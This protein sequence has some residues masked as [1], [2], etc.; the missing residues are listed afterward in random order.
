MT[1][2]WV[3][4]QSQDLSLSSDAIQ[5]TARSGHVLQQDAP[6]AVV[7]AVRELV[8]AVHRGSRLACAPGWT[9]MGDT[10]R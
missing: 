3:R 10:C 8:T 1:A 2:L 4:Q 6:G 9:A 5:V 7:E